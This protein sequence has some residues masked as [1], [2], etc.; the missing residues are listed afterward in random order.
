M[1]QLSNKVLVYIDAINISSTGGVNHLVNILNGA[2][3]KLH[4]KEISYKVWG[5]PRLLEKLPSRKNIYYKSNFNKSSFKKIIITFNS[6]NPSN[7]FSF[8]F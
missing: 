2:P 6:I 1:S 8:F 7:F 5:R 3:E 4:N